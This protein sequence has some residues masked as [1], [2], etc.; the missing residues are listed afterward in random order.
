MGIPERGLGPDDVRRAARVCVAAL[1]PIVDGD[2]SIHLEWTASETLDHMIDALG[3]CA[4]HLAAR[5]TERLPFATGSIVAKRDGAIPVPPAAL[6]AGLEAMAAVLADVVTAAPPGAQSVAYPGRPALAA[7]DF[8]AIGCSE[9][10]VHTDDICR[11]FGVPF[12]PPSPL[13]RKLVKRGSPWALRLNVDPWTALRFASGRI[14]VPPYGR[15]G[16]DGCPSRR[17]SEP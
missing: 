12:V 14:A 7:P 2:W 9:V 10:L 17:S 6:L 11:G 13:C 8:V 3:F 16:P 1:S 4:A 5:R 15:L